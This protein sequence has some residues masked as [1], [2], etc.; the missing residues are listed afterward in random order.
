MTLQ[1]I[2]KQISKDLCEGI[3][4]RVLDKD[5]APKWDP[6]SLAHVSQDMVDQYFSPLSALEPELEL[7]I[8]QREAFT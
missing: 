3:R 8:Q 4:A 7:P 1:A 6:P 2:Y 5:F